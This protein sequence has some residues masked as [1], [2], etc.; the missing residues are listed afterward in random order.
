[1]YEYKYY[2]TLLFFLFIKMESVWPFLPR[3]ILRA[4]R[5]LNVSNHLTR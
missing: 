1:M 4:A 3:T 2:H 5:F